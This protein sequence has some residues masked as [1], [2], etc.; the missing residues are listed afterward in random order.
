MCAADE[1]V[2]VVSD[3]NG[4]KVNT[5]QSVGFVYSIRVDG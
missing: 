2:L 3:T 5:S 4:G 1:D